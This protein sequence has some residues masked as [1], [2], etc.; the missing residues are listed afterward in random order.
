MYFEEYKS[1]LPLAA[2]VVGFIVVASVVG[3]GVS[4]AFLDVARNKI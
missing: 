1:I 3:A 2:V 4:G